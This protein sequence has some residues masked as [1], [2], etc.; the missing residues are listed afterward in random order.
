[1]VALA[2]CTP[3]FEWIWQCFMW[4]AYTKRNTSIN[5]IMVVY[6]LKVSKPLHVQQ[7][8][9]LGGLL[10]SLRRINKEKKNKRL[11]FNLYHSNFCIS[12]PFYNRATHI[13]H[14]RGKGWKGRGVNEHV[15]YTLRGC[16]HHGSW[17]RLEAMWNLW[18]VVELVQD[19][20]GLHQGKNGRVTMEFKV[21][22]RHIWRP[23][24][25]T[26]M[27]QRVLQWERQ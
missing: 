14:P 15:H 17:S 3:I 13:A 16:L 26:D 22:K 10:W 20:F 11:Y 9:Q 7:L 18:L 1:M 25:S 21:P 23:T 5:E 8:S 4:R 12:N 27:V 19:H 6:V 24:S 2:S